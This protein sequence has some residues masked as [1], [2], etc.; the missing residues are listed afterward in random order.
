[1]RRH[2]L[3]RAYRH[4]GEEALDRSRASRKSPALR[5]LIFAVKERYAA[6]RG[7]FPRPTPYMRR[8]AWIWAAGCIAWTADAVISVR[9]GNLPRAQLALL[10]AILFGIAFGYY[11]AQK[12]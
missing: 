3:W 7:E 1:M 2:Y 8:T 9:L 11:R 6:T 4:E 10:V 12:R 5:A